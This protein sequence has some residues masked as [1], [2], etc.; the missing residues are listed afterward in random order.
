MYYDLTMYKKFQ[1]LK[2]R[3]T[4]VR[5]VITQGEIARAP[6]TSD[7]MGYKD[8][9]ARIFE[10]KG[11]EITRFDHSYKTDELGLIFL[12]TDSVIDPGYEV[13]GL[14]GVNLKEKQNEKV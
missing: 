11:L 1:Y 9:I 13:W 12:A 5:V 14:I 6:K 3:Y 4:P 7:P 8:Y 10:E 2:T